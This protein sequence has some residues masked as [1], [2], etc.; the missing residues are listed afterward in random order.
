[1]VY[2]STAYFPP[3]SWLTLLYQ[4]KEVS[5]DLW[6]SYTKQSYRNRCRIATSNGLMDLSI[7]V[8]K[9]YGNQSKTR[10]ILL[11]NQ[12]NW[13]QNHWRGIKN[14]YQSTPFFI[15]YEE[16]IQKIINTDFE[17]LWQLNHELIEHIADEINMDYS[18]NYTKDFMEETDENDFR[19]KIH[20]KQDEIMNYPPY[21]Q[22]FDDKI[23]FQQGLSSL[24]L[25]FNLGPEAILYL[26]KLSEITTNKQ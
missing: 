22:V 23:G 10:D 4:K 16:G 21:Y 2:L 25:L 8:K 13:Q 3:I 6:E 24:D 19:F 14:A 17:F 12:Q 9:P 15:H 26:D 5:I 11:D 20:P 1:M 7:P 18:I